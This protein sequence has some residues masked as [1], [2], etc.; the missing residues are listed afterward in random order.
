MGHGEVA[1]V[2][3][4]LAELALAEAAVERVVHP[5]R[6]QVIRS[7]TGMRASVRH[8]RKGNGEAGIGAII[9]IVLVKTLAQRTKVITIKMTIEK[10]LLELNI[11]VNI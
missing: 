7:M 1:G 10:M 8:G 9:G 2:G 6:C 4:E 11:F 3:L 5:G